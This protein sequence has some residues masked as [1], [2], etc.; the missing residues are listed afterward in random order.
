MF[1]RLSTRIIVYT[2]T[3]VLIVLTI[4]S[5]SSIVTIMSL[6][7]YSLKRVE[8]VFKNNADESL[9][10]EVLSYARILKGDMEAKKSVSYIFGEVIEGEILQDKKI[11]MA[12]LESVYGEIDN[13]L[14]LR[15]IA[16]FNSNGRK[17]A[18]YP[19]FIGLENLENFVYRVS[20]K[21]TAKKIF[22]YD[23]HVNGDK[24]VSY[25]FIYVGKTL[26]RSPAYIAFDYNPY[27]FY[28]LVKTAQ[29][30]PYSPKYLWVINKDGFLIYDPPTKDHPLIT[31][32][33]KVN[34]ENPNNGKLLANIVKNFIL[35][36]KTGVAR[37]TFRGVDKFVGFTYVKECG[38]GLGLTL[39]TAIF[40][41]PI[42]ELN[43]DI[44]AKTTYTL[45]LFGLFSSLIVL[46]A[47]FASFLLS[48]RIVDPINR[49]VEA[50]E[51]ILGGDYH[52]RLPKCDITELDQLAESVNRLMDY[53][54][55]K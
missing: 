28:S 9:K 3:L 24:S 53:F 10:K 13:V 2:T 29:L 19:S 43:H 14:D 35:K 33:D 55:K 31:L 32:V 5:I 7:Q 40:Y 4:F 50:V 23:F 48:K 11:N 22:Y 21:P 1:D 41:K 37:Y 15:A 30:R 39:P 51:A 38:W 16:I 8:K 12:S 26:N 18:Q 17:I 27:D 34:L 52:R 36:G 20:K 44:N 54:D 42:R 47:I 49:T 25:S 45:A 6:K 46:F